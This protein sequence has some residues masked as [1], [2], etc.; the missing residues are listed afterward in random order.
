MKHRST[1]EHSRNQELR[2]HSKETLVIVTSVCMQM[3]IDVCHVLLSAATQYTM[4]TSV[5]V[6]SLLQLL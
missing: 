4:R 2:S 5:S 1:R 6:Q 3:R